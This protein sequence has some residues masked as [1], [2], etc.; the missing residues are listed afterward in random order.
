VAVLK[1]DWAYGFGQA[2]TGGSRG[3]FY[4]NVVFPTH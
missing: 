4:F 2:A 1:F 3:K